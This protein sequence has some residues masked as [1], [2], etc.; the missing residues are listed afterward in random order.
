MIIGAKKIIYLRYF[1]MLSDLMYIIKF[2]GYQI[3]R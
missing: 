3:L 2:L 1:Y